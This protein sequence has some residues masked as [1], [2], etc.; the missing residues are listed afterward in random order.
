[1]RNVLLFLAL[2]VTSLAGAI[3]APQTPLTG[4]SYGLQSPPP[5]SSR[6][7]AASRSYLDPV[8]QLRDI[9]AEK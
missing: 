9:L 4:A 8:Q 3:F 5:V 6:F 2:L 1:M 7:E